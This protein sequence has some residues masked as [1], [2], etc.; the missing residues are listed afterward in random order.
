MASFAKKPKCVLC[1]HFG[2]RKAI[3]ERPVRNFRILILRTYLFYCCARIVFADF[4]SGPEILQ[5]IWSSHLRRPKLLSVQT[6][7]HSINSAGSGNKTSC[8]MRCNGGN[9]RQDQPVLSAHST[10]CTVGVL[11]SH[12]LLYV[13]CERTDFSCGSYHRESYNHTFTTHMAPPRINLCPEPAG[14]LRH[15]G[16]DL[17]HCPRIVFSWLLLMNPVVFWLQD[18]IFEEILHREAGVTSD[19]SSV[20][21]LMDTL[22]HTA[23]HCNTLQHT[24]VHCN[25]PI[26]C[27]SVH[28]WWKTLQRNAT[29]CNALQNTYWRFECARIVE[30]TATHC[31]TLPCTATHCNTLQH[32]AAHC[33]RPIGG[34]SMHILLNTLQR[35]ATH[36]NAR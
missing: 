6:C 21:I 35:T 14:C 10:Q 9:G 27:S 30:H 5:G 12:K 26:A 18:W 17:R 7:L 33:K 29:H 8:L 31:N 20:H 15:F 19:C 2:A 25:T 22:Q 23:T 32:T 11:Q 28:I 34:S 4:Q 13:S 36:C 16:T 24:A 1:W 3:R